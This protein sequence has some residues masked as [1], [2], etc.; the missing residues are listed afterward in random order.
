[1]YT[2]R[3]SSLWFGHVRSSGSVVCGVRD[4]V[5]VIR[6]RMFGVGGE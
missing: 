5:I 1:M 6:V 2:A 3:L 4:G